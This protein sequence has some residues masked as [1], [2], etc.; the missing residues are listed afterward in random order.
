ML[1]VIKN[2][3]LNKIVEQ[4]IYE[5]YDKITISGGYSNFKKYRDNFYRVL[6]GEN[7]YN[8]YGLKAKKII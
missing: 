7:A 2:L 8:F 5:V 6:A 1:K 3:Q 4:K